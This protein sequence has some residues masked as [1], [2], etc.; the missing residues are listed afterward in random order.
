VEAL[1]R[2]GEGRSCNRM[3]ENKTRKKIRKKETHL[4]KH[5]NLSKTN[6]VP[7]SERNRHITNPKP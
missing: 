6:A 3:I 4:E 5:G 1:K 7:P 2:E